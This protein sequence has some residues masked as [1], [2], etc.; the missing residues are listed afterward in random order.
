MPNKSP[1]AIMKRSYAPGHVRVILI[2]LDFDL[3]TATA[4]QIT[5]NQVVSDK[6]T[7]ATAKS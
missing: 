1:L 6:D 3:D 2:E 4:G 5:Q 7:A